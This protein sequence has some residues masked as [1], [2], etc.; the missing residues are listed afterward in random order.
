MNGFLIKLIG[1]Y[2]SPKPEDTESED[3]FKYDL[4]DILECTNAVSFCTES[5]L[6]NADFDIIM[7]LE[8]VVDILN[9]RFKVSVA[10][11]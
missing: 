7:L 3:Y 5:N 9:E 2:K 8:N 10:T 6:E 1:Y 4:V 11:E